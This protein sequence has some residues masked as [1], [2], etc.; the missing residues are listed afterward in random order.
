MLMCVSLGDIIREMISLDPFENEISYKQ[1]M[2]FSFLCK[3][4][5]NRTLE[6]VT[7]GTFAHLKEIYV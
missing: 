1:Q 5:E 2:R 6:P 4:Y 3:A 7:V